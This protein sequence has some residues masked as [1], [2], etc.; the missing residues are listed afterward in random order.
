MYEVLSPSWYRY[1]IV[2][3]HHSSSR[4]AAQLITVLY[5]TVPYQF[6]EYAYSTVQY[7]TVQYSAVLVQYVFRRGVHRGV[8]PLA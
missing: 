2:A 1:G 5:A 6:F 7:S 4:G 3:G 8:S